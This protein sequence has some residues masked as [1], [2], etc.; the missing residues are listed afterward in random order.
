MTSTRHHPIAIVVSITVL[1]DGW[2]ATLG[3]WEIFLSAKELRLSFDTIFLVLCKLFV[4]GWSRKGVR[5]KRHLST[6][7]WDLSTN[8]RE[9]VR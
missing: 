8:E 4:G 5:H 2:S 6:D 3:T 7:E 9:V 1:R